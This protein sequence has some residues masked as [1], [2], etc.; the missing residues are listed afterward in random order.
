MPT[1]YF[2]PAKDQQVFVICDS[3]AITAGDISEVLVALKSLS[4]DRSSAMGAV[5]SR[6]NKPRM[7]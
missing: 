4:G 1:S 6:N 2:Y 3:A 5:L 7:S